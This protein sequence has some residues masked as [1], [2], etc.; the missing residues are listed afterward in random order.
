[1]QYE[2]DKKNK[3]YFTL[4]DLIQFLSDFQFHED[5]E[6]ELLQALQEL[7][8]G[9]DGFIPKRVLVQFLTSMGEVFT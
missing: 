7:D 5:T 2:I 6:E 4:N 9:A 8:Q 3:G 1:M